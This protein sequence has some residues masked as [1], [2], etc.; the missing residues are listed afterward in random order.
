MNDERSSYAPSLNVQEKH[1]SL[2]VIRTTTKFDF[3]Y[4]ETLGNIELFENLGLTFFGKLSVD[5]SYFKKG[6]FAPFEFR[7]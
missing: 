4:R 6:C 7:L 3:S 5:M 2:K 1:H